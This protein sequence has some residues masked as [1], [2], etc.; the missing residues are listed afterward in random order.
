MTL[1]YFL[2]NAFLAPLC[3]VAANVDS[4]VVG[5][6]VSFNLFQVVTNLQQKLLLCFYTI[7]SLKIVCILSFI[8]TKQL[9]DY[10]VFRRMIFSE[11]SLVL[12]LQFQ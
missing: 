7:F 8:N 6:G 4:S 1:K 12:V 2:I 9:F 11:T 10:F 5:G 3:Q